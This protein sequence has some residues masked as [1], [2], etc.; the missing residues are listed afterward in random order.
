MYV[1]IP[2]PV[3]LRKYVEY[4]WTSEVKTI[5]EKPL[6][7][8]SFA[9]A[10]T[11]L[12][13]HYVGDF[14]RV[15]AA[16]N[17]RK[18]FAAGFYGQTA[19]CSRYTTAA[20]KAG[21]F[22]VRFYPHAIPALFSVSAFELTGKAVELNDFLGAEGERLSDKIFAAQNFNRRIEIMSGFLDD[23]LGKRNGRDERIERAVELINLSGGQIK[24]PELIESF[25]LSER[26]FKRI[27]TE[28]AGF[29]PKFYSR[30]V[31]FEAALEHFNKQ[32]GK[33]LTETALEC[34]YF[35]Q[36]HFIRDFKEFSLMTPG[37]YFD[38]I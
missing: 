8:R 13:F 23:R 28:N 33:S 7:H 34:G 9:S 20:K 18:N 6:A 22:A 24:L 30:I 21:I 38:S 32:R 15:E 3:N 36:S 10:K 25:G 31:R 29:A 37:E 27:F 17:T 14:E 12:L 16:G 19:L 5:D 11:E 2:P 1:R 4:F 35:D 26:Q